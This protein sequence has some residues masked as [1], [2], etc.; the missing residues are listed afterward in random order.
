[1][2]EFQER[3]SGWTLV[4][5]L[6]LEVNFNKYNPMRGS[7]YIDLP[8]TI[9][10]KKA[11]IN[12][13]NFDNACFAWA[14]TS[15]LRQPTGVAQRVSGSQLGLHK[16]FHH[17]R[18][19]IQFEEKNDIS[20]NVYGIKAITIILLDLKRKMIYQLMCMTSNNGHRKYICE[21]CLTFFTCQEKLQRH[22]I[23]DCK[24]VKAVFPSAE[25]K[26]NKYGEQLPENL[27][28]F[29]KFERQL[30]IPFIVYAD[31]EAL[32]KP[33]DMTEPDPAKPFTVKCFEHV[34]YSFAYYVKCCFNPY[35]FAYYVKC[36]FNDSL[37]KLRVYRGENAA[38]TF[39]RELESDIKFLY[40]NYLSKAVG[41]KPLTDEETVGM[42]P[43][44][45]EES[46]S[47]EQATVCHICEKAIQSY[48]EKVRDHDHMTGFYRGAAHMV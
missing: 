44:T 10:K 8:P 40:E 28:K 25:L 30:R 6:Y 2:S 35:S 43:L 48:E 27:L 3:D 23:E 7:S 24:Q 33:I 9:K 41:M 21:G 17:I 12:L 36:C 46:I 5:I 31:F 42:K 18:I 16:E 11:V 22:E 39:I 38:D 47:Y 32:L 15:A 26:I 37:N 29:D 34:P 45:D 1:M 13:Q 20:I 4:N 14:I 19:M